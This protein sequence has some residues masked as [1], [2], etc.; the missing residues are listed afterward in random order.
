MSESETR[1]WGEY[2]RGR[3]DATSGAV[4]E[5][6]VL[7]WVQHAEAAFVAARA[8]GA[9][10]A[11]ADA[12]V[13][14]LIDQWAAELT[15]VRRRRF[16]RLA[17]EPP[18]GTSRGWAGMGHD[19]CYGVKLLLRQPLFTLV[20]TLLV[21][22]GVGA[23]T[24]LSSLTYA[25]LLKPLTWPDADR[26]VRLSEHRPGE[27]HPIPR[28]ITNGTY[29]AWSNAPHTID[30]IAGYYQGNDAITVRG[31]TRHVRVVSATASLFSVIPAHPLAGR[32]FAQAEEPDGANYVIVLSETVADLL[33]ATP[34]GAVG[35]DV[36]MDGHQ[37]R[38]IG[39]ADR[40]FAF[41]TSDVGA[42]IPIRIPP[43]VI[44]TQSGEAE[45][46]SMFG[47]IARLKPGVTPEQA[48][49]EATARTQLTPALGLVGMAVFGTKNKPIVSAVPY[50]T[51]LI[52]DVRPALYVLVAGV[53]LL[54]LVAIGNVA[55]MQL[56]RTT[57]RRREV[58]IRSAL[59]AAPSRLARQLMTE[60]LAIGGLGGLAGWLL[61]MALHQLL[62]RLL[63]ADFPRLDGFHADWR[64]IAFA[65]GSAVAASVVFGAAP[66]LL[67]RRLNLVQT[68]V[69]DGQAPTGPGVRTKVGRHV[70]ML[71]RRK[72]CFA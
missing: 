65:L 1:N 36:G 34:A 61:S 28:S 50:L 66:A 21:A 8:D 23:T 40:R 30:A 24:T 5:G 7:E 11:E 41:P 3:L 4:D 25:V 29:Y 52:A 71:L 27:T 10:A 56:A 33:F 45:S 22:V 49:A 26:L 9:S 13:R 63:P 39:V 47:G 31:D 42:W 57:T 44:S 37:Y 58:A 46:V 72:M 19:F 53:V 35:Q 62:P 60:N 68:L 14:G 48:A 43:V 69:E 15:G 67:A 32:F 51:A 20:A 64:V 55:G 12:Q 17:V 70:R 6:V 59:G 38:V 18:T 16:D 54:F 2:V